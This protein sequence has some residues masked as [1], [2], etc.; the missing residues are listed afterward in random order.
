MSWHLTPVLL[1][2]CLFMAGC[3]C[4]YWLLVIVAAWRFRAAPEPPADFAPP[5]SIFKP[6][7]GLER[8]CHELL[9]GF[10]RQDYPLYEVLF[11]VAHAEDPVVPV[12]RRLQAEF[13]DLPIRLLI[14]D[15]HYGANKKV[16][17]LDKMHREMRHEFLAVSDGDMRVGPDYLR[18]I[19]AHFRDPDVGLVTCFYRAEPGGTLPSVFEAIGITGEFHPS[20]M[21]ARMLEGVRFA[22]GSTMATRKSLLEAIGGFPVMADASDDYELGRR[23]AGLG[24]RVV[25]SPYVVHTVL[26]ADT[27]RTMVQRQFRWTCC[28]HASRSRGHTGLI[29]T[30]GFPFLLAGLALAPHSGLVWSFLCAWLVLRLGAAWIANRLVLHDPVLDRYLLLTPVRDLL[31]FGMWAASFFYRRATWRGE[32]IRLENGKMRRYGL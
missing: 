15:R 30:Y 31:T 32:Q 4:V 18:R 24:K 23:V 22:F 29:L 5:V 1:A 14:A 2:F 10:C 3:A 12:V 28:T 16:D 19:I 6:L 7:H 8:E 27:W 11:G 21:V 17:S 25:I 26:P 9:A 20:A 13:P